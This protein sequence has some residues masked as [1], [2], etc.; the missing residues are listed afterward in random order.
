MA[1][2]GVKPARLLPC[3]PAMTRALV[4]QHEDNEGPGL[5]TP[6]L[7]RAGFQ[8]HARMRRVEPGDED[9]PLVVVMGG[10]Q[11]VY[12]ASEHPY[13]LDE[14]R[15]LRS[16]LERGLPSL[17]IC[18]GSQLLAAA[19]GARVY[20]GERGTEIGL[21]PVACTPEAAKDEVFSALPA[22][23]QTLQWHGDTF[24]LPPGAAWLASSERYPHQAF[25][26][27]RSY[28]LQFHPELTGAAFLEWADAVPEEVEDRAALESVRGFPEGEPAIPALLE[29]L[30]A[31]LRRP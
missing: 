6:A 2:G 10:P 30:A 22:R 28:G 27:G 23:F 1:L 26:V 20:P 3:H 24:D 17:G 13:L 9:A 21:F 12:R 14:L 4:L 5:L 8:V 18:L 15:L 25:R 11:A 19:A 29:R 31:T 7:E 16:R